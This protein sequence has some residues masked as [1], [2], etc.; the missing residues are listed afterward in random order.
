MQTFGDQRARD[1]AFWRA[2]WPCYSI[3]L[4]RYDAE[5]QSFTAEISDLGVSPLVFLGRFVM[6]GK[7]ESVKFVHTNTTCDGEGDVRW[8]TYQGSDTK[9]NHYVVKVWND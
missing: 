6:D 9:G 4:F 3:D 2:A 5:T 1:K 8:W 7:R